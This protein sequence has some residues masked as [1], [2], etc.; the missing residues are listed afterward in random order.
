MPKERVVVIMGGPSSEY[1][2]SMASGKMVLDALQSRGLVEARALVIRRS[3]E[4]ELADEVDAAPMAAGAI[5]PSVG[6][7]GHILA[8]MK[9]LESVDAAFIALHGAFGEDGTMQALLDCLGIPY[10]GSGPLASALALNKHLAKQWLRLHDIPVAREYTPGAWEGADFPL[11]V[12][13]NQGGSSVGVEFLQSARDWDRL[14]A[15]MGDEDVLIEERLLGRELTC[16]VLEQTDG[17]MLPLP[18]IEI[19]PR[20]G[21][22][23]DFASKYEDGGADEICPAPLTP[24]M[25][26]TIG[27]MAVRAHTA[28][29]CRGF[30]RTDFFLTSAG[31]VVLEVNTIPGLTPNS[32]LPKAAAAAGIAFPELVHRL[33]ELGK[34]RSRR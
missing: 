12:K 9:L 26:E 25:T 11:V 6:R 13:P 18:P 24:E 21:A 22:F 7:R 10:T 3:G 29:G 8:G 32:L 17:G 23:F 33:L 2:V 16:A 1:S 4:W 30:S 28:L 15:T 19:V 14:A 5:Q 31:P 34:L 27:K 20:K